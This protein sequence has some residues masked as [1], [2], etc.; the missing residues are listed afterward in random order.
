[1]SLWVLVSWSTKFFLVQLIFALL[2]N[3]AFICYCQESTASALDSASES[4]V[5]E[6]LEKLMFGRICILVTYRRARKQ[7]PLSLN[8]ND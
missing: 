2:F 3:P 6:A 5:R 8:W 1:M 4:L 7:V